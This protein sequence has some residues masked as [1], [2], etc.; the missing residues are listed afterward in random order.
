MV[1]EVCGTEFL[2]TRPDK[3]YCTRRCTMIARNRAARERARKNAE[4]VGVECPYNVAVQC[5]ERKCNSCGWN[6]V[7][8]Q[9]RKSTAVNAIAQLMADDEPGKKV[10]L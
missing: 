5:H 4:V 8:A 1:C 10:G 7:V 6:P 9:K 3:K 2:Q